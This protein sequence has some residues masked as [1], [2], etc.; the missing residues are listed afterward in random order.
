MALG[1][2]EAEEYKEGLHHV[3]EVSYC[4]Y[5][6][7]TSLLQLVSSYY[8]STLIQLTGHSRPATACL[9][10]YMYIHVCMYMYIHVYT[11]AS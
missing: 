3:T 10:M 11:F 4:H 1:K 6:I 5:I 7:I 8:Q 9:Y 2:T